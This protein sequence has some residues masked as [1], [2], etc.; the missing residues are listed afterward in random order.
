MK[1]VITLFFSFIL[2]AS[3][4]AG[5][6]IKLQ[7]GQAS[8][9]RIELLSSNGSSLSLH[10]TMEGF[11]KSEVVTSKGNAWVLNVE[12]GA[13]NLQEGA[14]DV[15]HFT[16]SIIIPDNAS[17]KVKV[18]ASRYTDF[19][20]VH[21]IP[22][23][24]NLLRTVDPSTIPYVYGKQY[25]T[26]AFYPGT[27]A[28]LNEPYI[29]RDFRG[30]TVVIQPFQYNPITG[31]L[32]VY[33]DLTLEVFE[34]GISS[35]NAFN[36]V[37]PI[38]KIDSRFADVYSRHFLNYSMDDYTPV[39]E[40]GNMLIICYA[41]FL[42][43]IEPYVDWKIKTG[44]PVE[45]VDVAEIGDSSAIKNYIKNYYVLHGLTFVLLV[46]DAGQVPASMVGGNDSDVNYSYT[47]GN[48][49]Y[50]D[51]FVGRFSA[52]NGEHV[53]TQVERTLNYETNPVADTTWYR[54]AIGIASSEGPGDDNEYDYQHMRNIG[55]NKLL[56]YTYNYA[57]ELFDGSQGGNDEAGNPTPTMVA[58]AINAGAS[59]IN[60]TGHGSQ[61][62]WGSSG[63]SS[64]NINTMLT[65][66]GKLPFII[67]VACVNGDFVNATC[68][69]ETWMRKE[70]NSAPA[71]AVAT[72]MSTI[73]QSWNP[74]MCGQDA[75]NDILAETFENNIKHTFGGIT[76]N[77]CM[78]MNDDY[79]SGGDEMT[80]TWTI[81]G[82]PSLLIRTS[83]P[84]LM[85]VSHETAIFLGSTSFEVN[86][87]AEGGRAALSMDGEIIGTALV[88]N[89]VANITF[90]ELTNAGTIDVVVTAFNFKPY[91]G[92][93]EAMVAEGPFVVYAENFVVDNSGNMDGK[94]DYG[95]NVTLTL[96]LK[97]IG[98]DTAF[99]V[100][101][102]IYTSNPYIT[103]QT[104]NANFGDIAENDTVYAVEGFSFS[105]AGNVPD[106]EEI[107]FIL[108]AEDQ[109]GRS[110]WESGFYI[111]AHAPDL[112]FTGYTIDDSQGNNNGKIE[113]GE[114]A[115]LLIDITNSG[116]SAAYDVMGQLNTENEYLNVITGPQEIG[117]LLSQETAQLAFEILAS[118]DT[119]DGQSATLTLSL[120]ASQGIETSGQFFIIIGQKP[121]AV[122]N[123]TA[124]TALVDT[125]QAC[126]NELQ[127]GVDNFNTLPENLDIYRSAFVMLGVYPNNHALTAEEG[128]TLADFLNNGGRLYMEGGDTWK[129]D[130]QTDVHPMF[131]INA[132]DDGSDDLN[133]IVGEA[134]G[135]LNGFNFMYNGPNNYIDRIEAQDDEAQLILSNVS[136]YYG[137]TVAYENEVYKTI[138]SSFEFAGL[139][140]QPNSTKDAYMAIILNFFEINYTWTGIGDQRA[141]ELAVK[142][143]PNPFSQHTNITITVEKNEFV[144]VEI[145][146]LT[147][148]KVQTLN[149][150]ELSEGNYQLNWTGE[151]SGGSTAPAGIYYCKVTVGSNTITKKLVFTK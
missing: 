26:D 25:S 98:V 63:F 128:S 114:T 67:S 41:D 148:R 2:F 83:I 105:L 88:T 111:T 108:T 65:N 57:H 18:T 21:I 110:S 82:D 143:F 16:T 127:V 32:R 53:I 38:E 43:E 12:N 22:S 141:D 28:R 58:N 107:N 76:M 47:A 136:P 151:V 71:G 115:T 10:F 5:D 92:T 36:R 40:F 59:I 102:G 94:L 137:V 131:H 44:I 93:V 34:D 86:C 80:D 124:E 15:L 64:S 33:Y 29:V 46:G 77:G 91:T 60:Y 75:M 19:E 132:V 55:N 56:P 134:D 6:W 14:P 96:G 23:K 42:D 100:L 120:S 62:S 139:S 112:Q 45:V 61:N 66:V 144:S 99:S 150:R 1:K 68:F 142:A 7:S 81:F 78:Q 73:N 106:G 48:D 103:M 24:G 8:P 13:V 3:L 30:Q 138:G 116:S 90:D 130:E 74:P 95:E 97:N 129:F 123:L 4:Y 146:D 145:Y 149:Q 87:D 121:V 51:L 79:E 140:D 69:A 11:W 31:T 122:I 35:M 101:A 17:M 125:L 52:E 119:P 126:F 135:F 72:L 118:G 49:H 113:P 133:N 50:P 70:H 84:Q 37:K 20:G 54:K 9:P 104:D 147:G 39:D 117:S 27:V 85:T 109:S 89:G